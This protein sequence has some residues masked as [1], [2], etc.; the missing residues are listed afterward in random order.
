[1]LSF[2]YFSAKFRPLEE[3]QKD[4]WELH[5]KIQAL[6]DEMGSYDNPISDEELSKIFKPD[7][8][9]D[10][11]KLGNASILDGLN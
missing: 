7:G 5:L 11:D 1:M 2:H 8:K 6:K 10:Y 4:L 3:H 9:I